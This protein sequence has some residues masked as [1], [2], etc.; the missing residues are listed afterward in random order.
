VA[1][2][3]N[4][5]LPA[6]SVRGRWSIKAA[7]HWVRHVVYAEDHSQIRTAH[8]RQNLAAL[9]IL[10]INGSSRFLVNGLPRWVFMPRGLRQ[11]LAQCLAESH[12]GI[13]RD[14]LD[15]LPPELVGR[16]MPVGTPPTRSKARTCP[17]RNDS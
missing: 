10:V 9:R 15:A 8:V 4:R 11:M 16:I 2:P 12:R 5:V 6:T 17:S 13:N 7:L 1:L 3:A 14:D